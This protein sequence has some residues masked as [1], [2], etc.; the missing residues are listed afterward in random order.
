M[1]SAFD[2]GGNVTKDPMNH[3]L[4]RYS[5][6]RL[7]SEA[8]RDSI[9]AASGGIDLTMGGHPIFPWVAQDVLDTEKK[10]GKWDI[11]PDGPATWRRSVYIYQRRSLPFPMFETFD[12]P[13]MNLS[14]GTRNVSTVPTQALTMLNNPSVLRQAQLLADRIENGAPGDLVKQ[15]DLAYEYTLS[16]PATELER[17]IALKT[18]KEQSLVAFTHVLFNLSEFLYLR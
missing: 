5:P 4:W 2:H 10:K 11:Q 16:R 8:I 9:L 12:H 14:A 13:N 17:S 15:I 18:V 6:Q 1:V 7:D 3:L